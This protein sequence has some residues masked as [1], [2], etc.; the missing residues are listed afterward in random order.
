MV[1]LNLN[2]EAAD[3][4]ALDRIGRRIDAAFKRTREG[5]SEWTEGSIELMQA[6]REG[7]ER[8][9]G[10]RAFGKWLKSGGH[11]HVNKDDRAALLNMA[12]DLTIARDVLTKT[13]RRSYRLIWDETQSRFRSAAKPRR[14]KP[15][16][17]KQA[18][19]SI[20]LHEEVWQQA[21]ACAAAAKISVAE[22]IGQLITAAI[23]PKVDSKSLSK[24]AQDKLDAAI[25][26][27]K[28]QLD[29]EYEQ[30]RSHEIREHIKRIMPMLQEEKNAAW[31]AEQRYRRLFDE[32][33]KIF[34]VD[35]WKLIRNCIHP[36]A[37]MSEKIRDRAF[38]LF[39]TKKFALT[40]ED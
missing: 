19:R 17:V 40:G 23:D 28:R 24:T 2:S 11:D 1:V 31:E 6:L 21:K 4:I 8:F 15:P 36:D 14:T 35:E 32:Q 30:R 26:Q 25:R 39:N 7:R 12:S 18:Q 29:A 37:N 5:E 27:H 3:R 16:G 38:D 22:M 13:D 33:K 20:N 9:P 10:D 34:T